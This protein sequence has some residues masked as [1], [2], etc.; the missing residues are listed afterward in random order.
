MQNRKS[1]RL[2]S[3]DYSRPGSYFV[4]SCIKNR[5]CYFGHVEDGIMIH[6]KYGI[7]ALQQIQWLSNYYPFVDVQIYTVMPNHM[8]AIIDLKPAK[9]NTNFL[10]LPK[11]MAAYK[12]RVSAA[13]H[14]L[15]FK[16]FTWQRSYY[17]HIIRNMD[18]YKNISQYINA[19]PSNWK[20]DRFYKKG[21]TG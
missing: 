20:D 7:V 13:I 5:H 21:P 14:K 18:S 17:D 12:T 10:S 16:E 1:L 9:E 2:E 19:N 15:G 6:N 4:T 11:L 3:Y 8:H